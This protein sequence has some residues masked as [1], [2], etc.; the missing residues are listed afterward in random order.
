MTM[1]IDEAGP[2]PRL[3]ELLVCPLT[4]A[5][6]ALRSRR[7]TSWSASRPGSPTRSATGSRSC[8]ST[9]RGRSTTASACRARCGPMTASGGGPWPVEIRVRRAEQALEIDFDDGASF[10]YPAELLRVESPSAE[11][12][13]HSPGAEGDAGRQA[14]GR[15][16]RAGAGR[17]LCRAGHLRRRPQHRHLLL[18]LSLPARPRPGRD[19]AAYLDALAAQGSFALGL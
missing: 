16:H 17:Q 2:D 1:P 19:L 10:R 13:G 18:A 3:L 14:P 9:R 4:K 12:Q 5:S 15:H 6:A 8:W 7:A 11:V